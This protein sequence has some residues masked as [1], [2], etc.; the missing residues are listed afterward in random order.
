MAQAMI[1]AAMIQSREESMVNNFLIYLVELLLQEPPHNQLEAWARDAAHRMVFDEQ[2]MCLP[3]NTP[4]D[5]STEQHLQQPLNL[6]C[7]HISHNNSLVVV[8][9][10]PKMDLRELIN[11]AFQHMA[12]S[13][14]EDMGIC[15]LFEHEDADSCSLAN[16]LS[17]QFMLNDQITL[18][19]H[20]MPAPLCYTVHICNG[21]YKDLSFISPLNGKW[22]RVDAEAVSAAQ[23][24][25]YHGDDGHLSEG[26]FNTLFFLLDQ[27]G[28]FVNA[29]NLTVVRFIPTPPKMALA[30]AL[31][32]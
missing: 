26:N 14:K 3:G 9:I 13:S 10:D 24:E 18:F 16:M 30:A 2:L 29:G 25:H 5:C 22:V 23:Y 19:N 11:Y 12:R 8:K 32:I 6:L 1:Q 20:V 15:F 21:E 7:S 31:N 17:Y 28:N 27:C 4:C